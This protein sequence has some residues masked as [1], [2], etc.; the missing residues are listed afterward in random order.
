M[1]GDEALALILSAG[2]ALVAWGRWYGNVVM[3][4]TIGPGGPGGPA[5]SLAPAAC[6]AVLFL[7]LR[8]YAAHDVRDSGYLIFY[9]IMGAAWVGVGS[10]FLPWLGVSP[11]LDALERRNTSAAAAVAGALLGLTFAFAGGN[12]GNGPGWWVVV[13]SSGL[14]TVSL[15][16]GWAAVE[17]AGHVAESVAVERDIATGLRLAGMLTAAG[18]V[19]GRAAAGDWVSAGDTVRDFVRVGW[20]A[21]ILF[22]AGIALHRTLK[23]SPSHPRPSPVAC[24]LLPAL[25]YVIAAGVYVARVGPW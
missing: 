12:I 19:L 22:A 2:L 24:G 14:A 7:I 3:V 15:F 4:R 25:A 8:R 11:R 18:L 23:P 6:A 13:F 16:A 5:L 17:A 21:L 20:P 9:V 1:S 10:L